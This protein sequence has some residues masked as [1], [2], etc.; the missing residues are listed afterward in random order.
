[1]RRDRAGGRT[2]SGDLTQNST[3]PALATPAGSV[4]AA[5]AMRSVAPALSNRSPSWETASTKAGLPISR[6]FAP[7]RASMAPK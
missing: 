3:R 4:V 7:A 6:T 2:V 5:T 1:M